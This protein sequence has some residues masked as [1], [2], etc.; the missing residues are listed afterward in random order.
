MPTHR[1]GHCCNLLTDRRG[2][3]LV[4][5]VVMGAVLVGALFYVAAVGD[6][7]IFRTQLQDAAD[8]TAWKSAV[9]H[10]RGMNALVVL[11]VVMSVALGVFAL[12]RIVEVVLLICSLIPF[13]QAVAFPA[14]RTLAMNVEP[15]FFKFIN[16]ALKITHGL[17]GGVSAVVPWVAF[18]DAKGTPTS[19][20]TIWPVSLSL[21]PPVPSPRARRGAANEAPRPRI[22]LVGPAALPVEEDEFGTLCSK[23]FMIIPHQ[24]AELT[25]HIPVV[26][27]DLYKA[28]DAIFNDIARKVF[29]AGD[30][31]FCQ[32]IQGLLG[33][34]LELLADKAC[35]FVDSR[36][37]EKQDDVA[38]AEEQA[39]AQSGDDRRPRP[40]NPGSRTNQRGGGCRDLIFKTLKLDD[41][42]SESRFEVSAARVWFPAANGS[43]LT[44]VWTWA[45]A[46]SRMWTRDQHGMSVAARG[47][48]PELGKIKGAVALAE[49]YY[50]CA[51]GWEHRCEW[52]AMWAPAWTARIRRYRPPLRELTD[53]GLSMLTVTLDELE[54]SMS[55]VAGEKAGELLH[56]WTGLPAEGPLSTV[57]TSFI[58]S[59]DWF[60]DINNYT[61]KIVKNARAS[62]GL[63]DLLNPRNYSE[64][65][66]VH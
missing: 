44:H 8:A 54:R 66:R 20:D 62:S 22:P 51:A 45:E 50:D 64:P 18:G 30:G 61:K 29:G 60:Q 1:E 48:Q 27:D 55:E 59:W 37:Q 57:V 40:N 28:E 53:V 16:T 39:R 65:D 15:K 49:F 10:A 38:A 36:A 58:N 56:E 46:P 12:L 24:A 35:G 63:N 33:Q 13:V 26:G 19:A 21:L 4:P 52:D 31:I 14:F 2:A 3:I 47:K 17:E 25:R 34:L 7:I 42:V 41:I 5:A 11:N 43:P 32:P 6:A 23:G 9:W